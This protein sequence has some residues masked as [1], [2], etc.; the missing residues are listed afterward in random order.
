MYM[1]KKSYSLGTKDET[2]IKKT[3]TINV[4]WKHYV[5]FFS[6]VVL[7]TAIV[8]KGLIGSGAIQGTMQ[9]QCENG[10]MED[11][12]YNKIEYCGVPYT[13]LEGT[14]STQRYESMVEVIINGE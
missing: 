12:R 7:L 9:L 10:T 3:I 11:V 2:K 14:I 5:M 8:L 6:V 4:N 13:D 1:E